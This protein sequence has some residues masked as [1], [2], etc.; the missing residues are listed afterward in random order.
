MR[1]AGGEPRVKPVDA[2][3]YAEVVIKWLNVAY[4]LVFFGLIVAGLLLDPTWWAGVLV[5]TAAVAP[6]IIA[7]VVLTRRRARSAANNRA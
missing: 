6:I 1:T 7:D 2:D 3:L 4:L 5:G